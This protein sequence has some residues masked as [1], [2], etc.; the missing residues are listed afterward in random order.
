MNRPGTINCIKCGVPYLLLLS[1]GVGTK[2]GV[3]SKLLIGWAIIAF[4]IPA[5][6]FLA[7]NV[8][9]GMGIFAAVGAVTLAGGVLYWI[10]RDPSGQPDSFRS[11]S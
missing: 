5:A 6:G 1:R 9:G 8:G 10:F 7:N 2:A 3:Y 4:L 11:F